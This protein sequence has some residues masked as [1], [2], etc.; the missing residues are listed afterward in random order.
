[1][2]RAG[3]DD[4]F[5]YPDHVLPAMPR[6]DFGEGIGTNNEPEPGPGAVNL[7][8]FG[9]SVDGIASLCTR[10]QIRRLQPI[11]MSAG[12]LHHAVPALPGFGKPMEFMRGNS[13]RNDQDTMKVKTIASG[14][15]DGDMCIVD[16]VKSPPEQ[17]NIQGL[18]VTQV[19]SYYRRE[20]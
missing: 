5:G 17:S 9:Q 1:M 19:L 8:R 6:R 4:K 2:P 13:C 11:L 7:L 16:R 15:G 18:M 3:H 14:A 20:R 10:L 12:K